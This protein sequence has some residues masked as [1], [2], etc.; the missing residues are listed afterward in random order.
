[1]EDF[2]TQQINFRNSSTSL[3]M[4][5]SDKSLNFEN[6]P[7]TKSLEPLSPENADALRN[8]CDDVC[9]FR[10]IDGL[11]VQCN[12][13][14]NDYLKNNSL[15]DRS[16]FVINIKEAIEIESTIEKESGHD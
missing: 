11:Y 8:K 5:A 9:Y 15:V 2:I 7:S 1:M 4:T 14:E 13:E 12:P 10:L 3:K 6:V 16:S